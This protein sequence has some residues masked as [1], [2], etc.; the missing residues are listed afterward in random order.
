[1]RAN[2]TVAVLSDIFESKFVVCNGR[3]V[4]VND[5]VCGWFLDSR[6]VTP[7]LLE[8]LEAMASSPDPETRSGAFNAL[9]D[10]TDAR[11]ERDVPAKVR[12]RARAEGCARNDGK[13]T[14]F[15]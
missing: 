4:H 5:G 7:A 3:W 1:M 2:K 10:A 6:E 12:A 15:F 11:D 13:L 9:C 8:K 14:W